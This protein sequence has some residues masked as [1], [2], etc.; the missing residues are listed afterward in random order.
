MNKKDI[1]NREDVSALVN[2]FYKK[3]RVDETL[4]P[5]FNKVIKDWDEHLDR[6]TTFWETSLFMTKKLDK[7]YYGNPLAAHV[8]V[9]RRFNHSITNTHFGLWLNLW[10]ETLDE[11]FEGEVAENAK[12]R[13]R[14]MG[15]F[16]FM[17]IFAAR[18]EK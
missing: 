6:L 10:F 9:D 15:T 7:K 14:K 4:G 17:N 2:S 18:G 3:I 5:I 1:Q 16:M 12:R 11:L 8:E 13:A